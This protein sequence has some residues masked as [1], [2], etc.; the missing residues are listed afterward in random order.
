MHPEVSDQ[1]IAALQAQTQQLL[2][3]VQE[4]QADGRRRVDAG[5]PE[6]VAQVL[7]SLPAST[8]AA[9]QNDEASLINAVWASRRRSVADFYIWARKV[10]NYVAIV[11]DDIRPSL[12]W[13]V[14]QDARRTPHETAANDTD[15]T[16][17]SAR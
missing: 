2:P 9:D 12:A 14:E 4:V 15:L 10:G 1:A 5:V 3:A 16:G 11:H 13:T 6:N 17:K 8:T 7:T